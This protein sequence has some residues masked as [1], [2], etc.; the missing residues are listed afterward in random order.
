MAW[1]HEDMGAAMKR[2]LLASVGDAD[3]DDQAASSWTK[4]AQQE[5][6][7]CFKRDGYKVVVMCEA[8]SK[9]SGCVKQQYSLISKDDIV[10]QEQV[11]NP[12]GVMMYALAVATKY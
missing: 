9:G 3:W 7:E 8:V 6:F 5:I 4:R 1:N 10:V 2:I 11:T 12:K